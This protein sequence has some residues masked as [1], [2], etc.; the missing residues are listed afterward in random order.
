M[1]TF[2]VPVGAAMRWAALDPSNELRSFLLLNKASTVEECRTAID[3]FVTPAQNFLCVDNRGQTGIFQMGRFPVRWRGQG[4]M[5][6]DGSS[7]ADEWAGWIPGEQNPMIRNPERGFLSSANQAPADR[8]YPH[9]LGWPFEEP[10]R[11]SRINELLRAK[12]K[13]SPQDL[14]AM[15][16]DTLLIPA[17]DTK[18]LFVAAIDRSTLNES[19]AAALKLVEQWDSKFT[20]ESGAG[21]LFNA[22][23]NRTSQIM[24]MS[25][26]PDPVNYL[27]P[28]LQVTLDLIVRE[29]QSKWF[30]D[31][32]TEKKE[33]FADV[34][35]RGFKTALS[36]MN[37]VTGT[38]DS[39]KWK[40]GEVRPTRVDHIGRLP[41][42]GNSFSAPGHE[43][44]IFA[45]K[46]G[47]GP[48]WKVVVAVGP[49]PKA[50][51]IYPGGQS[52]DPLSPHYDDF[53]EPWRKNELKEVRFLEKSTSDDDRKKMTLTLAPKGGSK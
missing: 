17:R 36:D 44:A 27:R 19:E 35:R 16:G 52:G 23:L 18:K 24:W 37:D 45:N 14:I 53:L 5:I 2:A 8:A 11:S 40:W 43:F 38:S 9:Y 42:F 29:P 6:L 31:P 3:A 15:Q 39:S 49:K 50:W 47:H 7:A 10:F 34:A 12:Q 20:E 4:R 21:A 28:S 13:F 41:G 25:R 33:S 1:K 30:D 22:W 32:K 48:V 26:F 46:G 51:S